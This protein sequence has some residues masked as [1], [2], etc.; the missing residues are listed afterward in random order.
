MRSSSPSRARRDSRGGPVAVAASRFP[1][2]LRAAAA[3][4][5][6]ATTVAALHTLYRICRVYALIGIAVPVFGFATADVMHVTGDAWVLL[7]IGLTA[8]AAA[9]LA[10]KPVS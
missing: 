7:S 4:P 1:P 10:P 9:V 2:A 8:V 3:A 6:D 5:H